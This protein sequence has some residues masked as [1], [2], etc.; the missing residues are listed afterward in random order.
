MTAPAASLWKLSSGSPLFL[1]PSIMECVIEK[2]AKQLLTRALIFNSNC[3][4]RYPSNLLDLE[5]LRKLPITIYVITRF[6]CGFD[7]FVIRLVS[8][9]EW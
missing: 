9:D 5:S 4:T 2:P 1:Q 7:T 6:P 3:L 8:A